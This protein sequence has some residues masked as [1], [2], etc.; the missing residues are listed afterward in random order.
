MRSRSALDVVEKFVR[1]LV[2][3]FLDPN[4]A[5]AQFYRTIQPSG[6]DRVEVV[7]VFVWKKVCDGVPDVSG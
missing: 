2:L 5:V 3:P 6:G 1:Q 4:D 7:Q